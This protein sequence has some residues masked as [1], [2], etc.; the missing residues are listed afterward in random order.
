[1][2]ETGLI[3][4]TTR[5]SNAQVLP[6]AGAVL[7][8]IP[9]HDSFASRTSTRRAWAALANF[10]DCSDFLDSVEFSDDNVNQL[11]QWTAI[12]SIAAWSVWLL[13]VAAHDKEVA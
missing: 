2:P 5:I 11:P 6:I 12:D 13:G 1:M 10:S 3:L 8:G 7:V 9:S 4:S